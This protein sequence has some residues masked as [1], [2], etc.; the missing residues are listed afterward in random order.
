MTVGSQTPRLIVDADDFV[1]PISVPVQI[2]TVT[3]VKVYADDVLLNIGTNYSISGVGNPDGFTVLIVSPA[4]FDAARWV[5]FVDPPVEQGAD[6]SLGGTFGLLYENALDAV[7]RALRGVRN[8]AD[9]SITLSPSSEDSEKLAYRRL[10][11]T[12]YNEIV[13]PDPDTL[14]FIIGE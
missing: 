13:E 6:L 10:T 7:V 14:Y 2:A 5:V 9:R 3:H 4:S 11:I 12:E 8:L 1:N